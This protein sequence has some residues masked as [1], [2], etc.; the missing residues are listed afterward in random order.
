MWYDNILKV[1][2]HCH[3]DGSI[4]ECVLRKLAE[5]A[6]I[7]IPC[8]RKEFLKLIHA[9]NDCTSLS[10]YLKAFDLPLKCLVNANSFYEA[11]FDLVTSA[12][13][14]NVRYLEL[15][16]A[17]LLSVSENLSC[18]TIIESVLNGIKEAEKGHNIKALVIICGMRNHEPENNIK[19][20]KIAKDYLNSGVC[21]LDLAGD[22]GKYPA[23]MQSDFF[24]YAKK[25]HIPFTI[26]AG[27]CGNYNNIIEAIDLGAM[28]IGHGIA[29]A[30]N[31]KIQ[32]MCVNKNIG[33]EMCPSSNLQTKAIERWEDYPLKE[34]LRS[35]IKISVN[36]DNRTVTNTTLSNEFKVLEEKI[37]INE[38]IAR[39]ITKNSI[40]TSFATDSIKQSVLK[41]IEKR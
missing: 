40:E 30:G 20:A 41:E 33:V 23:T 29:M 36:T 21:G 32:R 22:E 19:L 28:R 26:H 6:G 38:E 8:E 37:G 9:G 15:R 5:E 10:Q 3:L 1:E 13:K 2:L 11:A 7:E 27:E 34:F 17:P 4:R 25:E 16:F 31:E 24:K 35:D 14:E 18:S 39:K 12:A